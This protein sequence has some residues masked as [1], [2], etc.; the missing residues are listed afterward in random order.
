MPETTVFYRVQGE[1]SLEDMAEVKN[2]KEI[3]TTVKDFYHEAQAA[4][5]EDGESREVGI[6][7]KGNGVE[8]DGQAEDEEE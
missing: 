3:I 1:D 4:S 7:V 5:D 2:W 8:E 6:M